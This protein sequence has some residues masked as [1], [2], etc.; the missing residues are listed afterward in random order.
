MGIRITQ[1]CLNKKYLGEDN[2]RWVFDM[3]GV[4]CFT[5]YEIKDKKWTYLDAE[6]NKE[7]I[8]RI[9]ELYEMGEH[10]T[11]YTARG[12]TIK[13]D[14]KTITEEQLEEWGVKYHELKFGKPGAEVYVDDRTIPP[15]ELINKWNYWQGIV[16][17]K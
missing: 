1:I 4:I 5:T 9:N 3:D 15:E 10:I 6:P 11:I 16:N 7:I 2:I 8:D 12:S 14:W 17:S 13:I